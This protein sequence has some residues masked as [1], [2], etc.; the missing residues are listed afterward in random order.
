MVGKMAMQ[1]R[2]LELLETIQTYKRD[3]A[4]QNAAMSLDGTV[5]PY[6]NNGH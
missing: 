3:V 6:T 2:E 4:V 1:Q 5:L